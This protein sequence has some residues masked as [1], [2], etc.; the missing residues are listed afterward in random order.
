MVESEFEIN[1]LPKWNNWIKLNINISV[2]Q[3]IPTLNH[4]ATVILDHLIEQL[5][6]EC[7]I[8]HFSL[9]AIHI[10]TS[11]IHPTP[12][13]SKQLQHL[14]RKYVAYQRRLLQSFTSCES[15]EEILQVSCKHQ[16][17]AQWIQYFHPHCLQLFFLERVKV[18][19][20]LN[21]AEG[22]K[23]NLSI[24]IWPV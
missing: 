16:C 9:Y 10:Q 4:E 3:V 6:W 5:H 12:L 2:H 20:A 17:Q 21:P 1:T 23:V 19:E 18:K 8:L 7:A 11:L 15:L 13:K 24:F 14:L 22:L